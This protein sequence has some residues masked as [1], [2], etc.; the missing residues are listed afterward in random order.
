MSKKVREHLPKKQIQ[1]QPPPEAMRNQ[2][3]RRENQF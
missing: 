2:A 1:N 3:M